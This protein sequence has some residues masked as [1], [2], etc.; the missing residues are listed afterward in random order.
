LRARAASRRGC[1]GYRR[2]TGVNGFGY[3]PYTRTGGPR[4]VEPSSDDAT[5]RSIGRITRVLDLARRRGRIGGGRLT[6]WNTEFGYQSDP[7]DTGGL[8]APIGRIPGFINEAEWMSFR[9]RRVASYSQY[10]L[11][12]D[13]LGADRDRFGSWQGGLRFADFRP[14]AG[15]Y[16]AYRLPLFVRLLG[17]GAVEVWGA[18]R[19]GGAGS[20]VQVQQRSRGGSYNNLGGPITVT[21]ARG[22]FRARF[23]IAAAARR[24]F[25]FQSSGLTSRE[26]K[27]VVR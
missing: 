27:A 3:H 9:N 8:G 14:K 24:V 10:T 13:P 22:Y 16:A 12:D 26:A 18:A 19:P 21:N 20:Q 4:L 6:V 15:V 23:R 11:V 1:R 2:L 25:R 5:I 17:P 7:P